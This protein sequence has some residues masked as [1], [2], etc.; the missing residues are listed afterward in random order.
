M[1]Q[2]FF[3]DRKTTYTPKVKEPPVAAFDH[4][5]GRFDGN[6]RP[7]LTSNVLGTS[8]MFKCISDFHAYIADHIHR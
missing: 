8:T 3:T 4:P 6:D 7:A 2:S 5:E 1:M